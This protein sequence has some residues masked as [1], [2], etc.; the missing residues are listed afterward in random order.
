MIISIKG[1]W[2]IQQ[3]PNREFPIFKSSYELTYQ[4]Y[5]TGREILSDSK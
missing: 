5:H 4:S 2:E 1:F 3:H